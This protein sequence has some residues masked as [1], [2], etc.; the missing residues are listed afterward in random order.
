MSA[1]PTRAPSRAKPTAMARPMPLPAPVTIEFL[2]RSRM[3]VV[4]RGFSTARDE[5]A[6]ARPTD[7]VALL[8]NHLSPADGHDRIAGD[9]EAVI[10]AVID[11]GVQALR[12]ERYGLGRVEE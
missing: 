5:A 6:S 7:E 10:R 2:S 4:L 11:R 1:Q 8:H 9:G 12:C 3:Q